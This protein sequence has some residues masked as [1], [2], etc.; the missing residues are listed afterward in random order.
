MESETGRSGQETGTGRLKRHFMTEKDLTHRTI[1]LHLGIDDSR[2]MI[3]NENEKIIQEAIY[4][5][6]RELFS[7]GKQY[8]S[9][10]GNST[11]ATSIYIDE[12][13]NILMDIHLIENDGVDIDEIIRS[14]R[15][16]LTGTAEWEDHPVGNKDPAYIRSLFMESIQFKSVAFSGQKLFKKTLFGV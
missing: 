10:E 15:F 2:L 8:F 6:S 9:L 5:F 16:Y 13:R 1:H 12:R 11:Y 4:Q 3:L 7:K 14:G